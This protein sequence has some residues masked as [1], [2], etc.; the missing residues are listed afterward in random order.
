MTNNESNAGSNNNGNGLSRLSHFLY[1]GAGVGVVSSLTTLFVVVYLYGQSL[2][3]SAG[4]CTLLSCFM[5]ILLSQPTGV[6]GIIAGAVIG[7]LCG[8]IGHRIHTS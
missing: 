7:A 4:E 5:T 6:I 3:L 1:W 2:G 8:F